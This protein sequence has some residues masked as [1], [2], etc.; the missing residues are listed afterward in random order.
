MQ[1]SYYNTPTMYRHQQAVAQS[2]FHTGSPMH[3]SWYPPG[4][5]HAQSGQNAPATTYCMQEEQQLWHHPVHHPHS[6]YHQDFNDFVHGGGS[7][8]PQ[9]PQIANEAQ[10]HDSQLPSPPITVSGSELS[11]S[12]GTGG[13]ISPAGN[14]NVQNNRPAPA[15][16][17]YEWIKKTSYQTQPNPGE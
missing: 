11:A 5:H 3:H 12:P 8:M 13:N 9:L 1:V 7:T 6:V 15:R 10:Q 4:Y 14:S 16:S 2:Q 17:P